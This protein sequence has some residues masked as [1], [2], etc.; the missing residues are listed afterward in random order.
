MEIKI[1]EIADLILK[2]PI[3]LRNLS[4]QLEIKRNNPEWSF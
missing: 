3:L 1:S 2:N 4:D